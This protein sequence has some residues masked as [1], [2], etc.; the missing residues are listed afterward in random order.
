MVAMV[1][2]ALGSGAVAG[3]P[4]AEIKLTKEEQQNFDKHMAESKKLLADW[5]IPEAEIAVREALCINP[6]SQE[7]RGQLKAV[8][9]KRKQWPEHFNEWRCGLW[10]KEAEDMLQRGWFPEA[11]EALDFA[12]KAKAEDPRLA[13]LA[14]K[15]EAG[16]AKEKIVAEL[17][18]AEEKLT[19]EEFAA[20]QAAL[21]K[22]Q[23][24][25]AQHADVTAFAAKL[26]KAK[27][28]AAER[29]T[30]FEAAMTTAKDGATNNRWLA[31]RTA[32]D[33]AL[34]EFPKSDDALKL[35]ET[36]TEALAV[37]EDALR[38]GKK[39]SESK[40][41]PAA[42]ASFQKA[43]ELM[44]DSAEAKGLVA[45]AEAD[46][47]EQHQRE[48]ERKAKYDGIIKVAEQKLAAKDYLAAGEQVVQAVGVWPDGPSHRDLASAVVEA[49]QAEYQ[50]ALDEAKSAIGKADWA[51]AEAALG[52]AG[53][54]AGLTF[55]DR[56][57]VSVAPLPPTERSLLV[58]TLA[59]EKVA[60]PGRQAL[61]KGDA[62]M[63]RRHFFAAFEHDADRAYKELFRDLCKAQKELLS[64]R[65]LTDALA[66]TDS[67]TGLPKRVTASA[68]GAT[69]A[70]VP[71]GSFRFGGRP[72]C[73]PSFYIEVGEVSST[74]Y[75][76]FCDATGRGKPWGFGP[77]KRGMFGT[78]WGDGFRPWS[79]KKFSKMSLPVVCVSWEAAQAYAN[80]A[81][82][83]LPTEAQWERAAAGAAGSAYPWGSQSPDK[84]RCVFDRGK[85][86]VPEDAA[87]KFGQDESAYGVLHLAGNVR[88]WCRDAYRATPT[89]A[90]N[91]DPVTQE[92]ATA[93]RAVRG[94]SFLVDNADSLKTEV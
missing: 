1:M 14:A 70:L 72:I 77:V 61:A 53:K 36:I 20:A 25:D 4:A 63:A 59:F 35:K 48:A 60:A 7:A 26:A 41:Y 13:P 65:G 84:K 33:K 3:A 87:T 18:V 80:W 45:K 78:K 23:A 12:R 86:G 76:K 81:K 94:G 6:L 64:V 57:P 32:V 21:K 19:A 52:Q 67:E 71:G 29:L 55:P 56:F 44:P 5:K 89:F 83:E 30:R 8:E 22:A 88:E 9:E 16:I 58:A 42:I 68:D 79:D 24:L 38:K 39:A 10:L 54:L 31:A 50:A 43:L 73:L 93:P 15:I 11:K 74:Q 34:T 62:E 51:A 47:K 27:Q 66:G 75:K 91:F 85:G 2:M 17:K 46:L 90:T 37:Y 28:D 49:W 40:G 82:R 69:L 92:S